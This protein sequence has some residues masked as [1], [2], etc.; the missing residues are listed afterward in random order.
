[1]ARYLRA[2]TSSSQHSYVSTLAVDD[3][4]YSPS[5][6]EKARDDAHLV[7]AGRRNWKT[8]R[9]KREAVWSLDLYAFP[10]Y[11]R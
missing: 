9:G 5:D 11:I 4:L 10:S 6:V 2:T 1:M 3:L 7:A 8:L